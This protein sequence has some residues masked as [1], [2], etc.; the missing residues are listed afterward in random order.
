MSPRLL[1]CCFIALGFST[2]SAS[3]QD[4]VP[5][6]LIKV[7]PIFFVPKGEDGPTAEQSK[8]LVQHLEMARARYR[9]LLPNKSTFTIADEQPRVYR[10]KNTLDFLRDQP[11][12]AAP[13][14][15]SPPNI[16]WRRT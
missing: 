2:A 9:E 11:E 14:M 15:T 5:P 6:K 12:G 3:A 16:S 1:A 7:L 10:S 8:R 13:Q 4:M